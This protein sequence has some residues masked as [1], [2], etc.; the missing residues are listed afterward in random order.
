GGFGY[1]AAVRSPMNTVAVA[2]ALFMPG[3][4]FCKDG[5]AQYGADQL[6]APGS[7]IRD[8]ATFIAG[9]WVLG[10]LLVGLFALEPLGI[11]ISAVAAACALI[12]LVIA[13]KGQIISTRKVIKHAPWQ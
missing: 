4:F 11:P 12:L 13:G 9:W 6:E 1:D 2:A 8:R 7:V 10:L 5:P 3:M